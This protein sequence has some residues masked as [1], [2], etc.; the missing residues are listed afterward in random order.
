MDYCLFV[1]EWAWQMLPL[2]SD[3]RKTENKCKT[4]ACALRS[5]K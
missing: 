4:S 2:L 3:C 5:Q 1:K